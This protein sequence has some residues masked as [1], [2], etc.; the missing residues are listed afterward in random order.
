MKKLF[1]TFFVT[2]MAM[3]FATSC[4]EEK[5]DAEIL[6]DLAGDTYTGQDVADG[7]YTLVLGA[8]DFNLTEADG[9]NWQG[10]F[11]V[12]NGELVLSI[13]TMDGN[14]QTGSFTLRVDGTSVF[15][16]TFS[17]TSQLYDG[18]EVELK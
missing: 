8:S 1:F 16:K 11:N 5:T 14:P 10:T 18:V 2:V 6:A 9:T 4:V 13:T 3:S 12:V 15:F 7:T 17:N